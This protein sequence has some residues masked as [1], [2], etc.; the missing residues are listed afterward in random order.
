MNNDEKIDLILEKMNSL[1]NDVSGIYDILKAHGEY[2]K[3]REVEVNNFFVVIQKSLGHLNDNAYEEHVNLTKNQTECT[4]IIVNNL[5]QLSD[6]ILR[7]HTSLDDNQVLIVDTIG[8]V[9]KNLTESIKD[10]SYGVSSI[11]SSMLRR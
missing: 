7:D 8:K 1:E 11:D 10:V 2:V 5:K 9:Y 6:N 4:K 3:R